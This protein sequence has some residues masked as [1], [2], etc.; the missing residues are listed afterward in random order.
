MIKCFVCEKELRSLAEIPNKPMCCIDQGGVFD[1]HF[2]YGSNYDQMLLFE[3]INE[4]PGEAPLITEKTKWK[5][6]EWV[7]RQNDPFMRLMANTK[8]R[9][10]LCDECLKKKWHLL[11]GY[12][13]DD[14]ENYTEYKS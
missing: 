13:S 7:E 4:T 8:V 11:H 5:V 10:A 1:I 9:G 12:W 2:G 14:K 6:A 3:P